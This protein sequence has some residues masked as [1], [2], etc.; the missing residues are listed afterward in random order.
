LA[1]ETNEELKDDAL[2]L[3]GE[4]TDGTSDFESKA[5]DY[6]NAVQRT[7]VSGGPLGG[8]VLDPVDWLW[9]IKHPRGAITLEPKFTSGSVTVALTKDSTSATLSSTLS[10]SLVGYRLVIGSE[11]QVPLVISVDG[12][13]VTL[14]HPWVEDSITFAFTAFKNEYDLATDFQRFASPLVNSKGE[15][16]DVG[17]LLGAE[18]FGMTRSRLFAVALI[19]TRR[20]RVFGNPVARRVFEYEYIFQPADLATGEDADE[21]PVPLVHRRILSLGA[22][23]LILLDKRDDTSATIYQQFATSWNA[24]D[25]EQRFNWRNGSSTWGLVTPRRLGK[26][27]GAR[28]RGFF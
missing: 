13:D 28:A 27:D 4:P 1:F 10:T 25:T 19:G 7:L 17:S 20:L 22:A 14:A 26:F 8:A 12:T 21:S 18:P 3:A 24:M 6:V 16:I 23:Y 15:V 9:A 5:L 11:E 2:F